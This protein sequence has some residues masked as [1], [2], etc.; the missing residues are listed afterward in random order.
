MS[1]GL[2]PDDIKK[3]KVLVHAYTGEHNLKGAD[4]KSKKDKARF[5][6][7]RIQLNEACR[8]RLSEFEDS[9]NTR[10]FNL[11]ITRELNKRGTTP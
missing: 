2:T 8:S 4:F 5:E 6:S 3:A 7:L 11:I 1:T 10:V 9:F